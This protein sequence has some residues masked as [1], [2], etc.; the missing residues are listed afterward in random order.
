MF[1]ENEQFL[2]TMI[3]VLDLVTVVGLEDGRDTL[4]EHRAE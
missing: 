3:W 2:V 1:G 4:V